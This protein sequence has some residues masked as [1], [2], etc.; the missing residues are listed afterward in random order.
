MR[1]TI[2]EAAQLLQVPE[3]VVYKW[4]RDSGLPAVRYNEQYR[5]NKVEL[6]EWAQS[7]QVTLLPEP[8]AK[9]SQPLPPLAEALATGGIHRGLAGRNKREVLRAVVEQLRLPP[10]ADREFLFQMLMAREDQGSTAFGDGIAIPHVR[11]PI[12]LRIDRPAVTLCFLESPVDFGAL[13]QKPVFALF[14]MV[15]P[16]IRV[17]LHLLSRLAFCLKS[18]GFVRRLK[19]RAGEEEILAEARAVEARLE[20]APAATA[21]P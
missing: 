5:L 21:K 15:N 14:T 20:P 10:G 12:V 2:R 8:P 1:L 9:H 7:N 11:N 4:I 13:D 16:T 3:E 17:H 6:A 18:P 19:E